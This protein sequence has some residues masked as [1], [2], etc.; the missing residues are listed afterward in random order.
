MARGRATNRSREHLLGAQHRV[1]TADGQ[2]MSKRAD[3]R[4]TG[5]YRIFLSV[6][7]LA[8]PRE[9][10]NAMISRCALRKTLNEKRDLVFLSSR[11]FLPLCSFNTSSHCWRP[12]VIATHRRVPYVVMLTCMDKEHIRVSEERTERNGTALEA[13]Y[14]VIRIRL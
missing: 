2:S 6:T 14:S 13:P 12:N 7:L 5:R 11:G 3:Q 10:S 8:G 9:A 4:G 1:R